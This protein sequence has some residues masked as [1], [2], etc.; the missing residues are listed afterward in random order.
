[1][2]KRLLNQINNTLFSLP[3]YEAC[4]KS[5]HRDYVDIRMEEMQS[6]GW[7]VSGEMSTYT[8]NQGNQWLV[9]PFR[10]KIVKP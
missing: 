5:F 9:V 8:C 2:I 6:K 10:R 1:M 4:V 3:K 7:I